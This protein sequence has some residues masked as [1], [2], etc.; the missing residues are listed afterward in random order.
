M[1]KLTGLVLLFAVAV[2]AANTIGV[3]TPRID[4]HPQ[5]SY[6]YEFY[7][8][9]GY[10]SSGWVWYT[11]GNYWAVQF[12]EE[13]TGGTWAPSTGS[14]PSLTPAGPTAPSRALICTSFPIVAAI[15]MRIYT[16]SI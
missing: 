2:S 4:A 11:G 7:W 6:G 5:P 16:V 3:A 1:R 15:P 10:I 8:D 14:G 9:D 13:K 12:D